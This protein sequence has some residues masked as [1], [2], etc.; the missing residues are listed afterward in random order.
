MV[1]CVSSCT[2][3]YSSYQG[4]THGLYKMY[5]EEIVIVY[6]CC[7]IINSVDLSAVTKTCNKQ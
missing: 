2:G 3:R 7:I 1:R 6:L 4:T 5:I